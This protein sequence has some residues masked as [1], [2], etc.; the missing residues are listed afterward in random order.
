MTNSDREGTDFL[1]H[2]DTNYRFF[3]LLTIKYCIFIFEKHEKGFQKFLNTLRWD[4]HVTCDVISTL[5]CH[6][7]TCSRLLFVFPMGWYWVCEINRIHHWCSVGT[8]KSQP[9]GPPFQWGTRLG[10]FLEPLITNDRF[11]FSYTTTLR[12]STV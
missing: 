8:E 11:F 2:P 3:F 6:R 5:Q 4:K 1:F 12:Y 9:E 7:S 10:I